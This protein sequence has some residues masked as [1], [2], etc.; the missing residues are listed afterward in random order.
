MNYSG[1]QLQALDRFSCYATV[2]PG[3]EFNKESKIKKVFH[4]PMYLIRFRDT[5]CFALEA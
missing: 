5:V 3:I 4:L 1:I 2:E